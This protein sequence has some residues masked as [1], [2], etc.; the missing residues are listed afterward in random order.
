MKNHI[1]NQAKASDDI[2]SEVIKIMAK[3]AEDRKTIMLQARL[4]KQGVD[5]DKIKGEIKDTKGDDDE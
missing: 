3:S 1:E 2:L 5:K 4:A